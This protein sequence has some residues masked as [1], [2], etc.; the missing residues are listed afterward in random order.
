MLI[1]PK[2]ARVVSLISRICL[3]AN[4]RSEV[5]AANADGVWNTSGATIRLVV[6]TPFY[7]RAWFYALYGFGFLSVL[8]RCI[9][10][11]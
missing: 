2:Q 4:I 1:G 8:A 3:T 7:R 11:G 10:T 9:C 6:L 5:I